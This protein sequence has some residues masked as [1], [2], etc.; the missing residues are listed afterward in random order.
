MHGDSHDQ[1]EQH[2]E[3]FEGHEGGQRH[4]SDAEG[5]EDVDGAHDEGVGEN[6][7]QF[8]KGEQGPASHFAVYQDYDYPLDEENLWRVR[9]T[10]EKKLKCRL[11]NRKREFRVCA[12]DSR[13]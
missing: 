13:P 2:Y 3:F 11:R 10:R 9:R 12:I 4:N 8:P 7:E 5:G 1:H 6:V